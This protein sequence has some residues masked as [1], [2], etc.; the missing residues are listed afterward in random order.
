MI[1]GAVESTQS[2]LH[3]SAGFPQNMVRLST[4]INNVI[5]EYVFFFYFIPISPRKSQCSSTA[6]SPTT[7][8]HTH[9]HTYVKGL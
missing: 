3:Y 1:A 9:T 2:S 7:H 8:T 4:W 5:I 6:A